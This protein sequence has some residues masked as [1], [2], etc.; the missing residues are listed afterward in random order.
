MKKFLQQSYHWLVLLIAWFAVSVSAMAQDVT[1]QL[2]Q[3]SDKSSEQSYTD[4]GVT[5]HY[6][7]DGMGQSEANIYLGNWPL[8]VTSTNGKNISKIV[9]SN[10]RSL[11]GV[12]AIDGK[13]SMTSSSTSSCTWEAGSGKY[14]LV[15]FKSTTDCYAGQIE[16]WFADDEQGG[17]T[18][19][20]TG[21]EATDPNKLSAGFNF[22]GVIPY[23]TGGSPSTLTSGKNLA[24]GD[25]FEA[26]GVTM[27]MTAT[28]LAWSNSAER[29]RLGQNTAFTIA[30]PENYEITKIVFKTD[31]QNIQLAWVQG[32][33]NGDYKTV[34]WTGNASSL[35]FRAS[36]D[37]YIQT[38]DVTCNR[39]AAKDYTVTFSGDVPEGC[40]ATLGTQTFTAEGTYSSYDKLG[41]DDLQVSTTEDYYYDVT[42]DEA[43]ATYTVTFTEYRHYTV[44]VT[45]CDEEGA[46]VRYG[47]DAYYAGD[48]INSKEPLT[49]DDLFV[50]PVNGYKD[51]TVSVGDVTVYVTYTTADSNNYTVVISGM[52]EAASVTIGDETY[53]ANGTYEFSSNKTYTG[54][55]V[56]IDCPETHYTNDRWDCYDEET[57]T[58]TITFSQYYAYSVAVDGESAYSGSDAGVKTNGSTY[59]ADDTIY[60]RGE[61][62]AADAQALYVDGYTGTVDFA[63]TTFT[64][65]Y[66]KNDYITFDAAS[67]AGYG[68]YNVTKEGVTLTGWDGGDYFIAY[69]QNN[70][71]F[72]INSPEVPVAKVV[73]DYYWGLPADGYDAIDGCSKG[74]M[75]EAYTEWT[76]SANYLELWNSNAYGAQPRSI[77]VYL[78]KATPYTISI[79]GMPESKEAGIIVNG[80]YYNGVYDQ[81]GQYTYNSYNELTAQSIQTFTPESHKVSTTFDATSKTFEIVYTALPK[82]EVVAAQD[83]AYTGTE[84]VIKVDCGNG[85][86]KWA[87]I[88]GAFY[89]DGELTAD[90]IELLPMDGFTGTF[91]FDLTSETITVKYEQAAAKTYT[92]VFAGTEIPESASVTVD[93]NTVNYTGTT[94]SFESPYTYTAEQ[95]QAAEVDGYTATVE[96]SE[97]TFTVTYTKVYAV[98]F[99]FTTTEGRNTIMIG[100]WGN[101]NTYD[102]SECKESQKYNKDGISL[103]AQ[104]DTGSFKSQKSSNRFYLNGDD[105]L[106]VE[107]NEEWLI[108]GVELISAS[109]SFPNLMYA[110]SAL[111]DYGTQSDGLYHGT[112]PKE[113]SSTQSVKSIAFPNNYATYLGKIIVTLEPDPT[114]VPKEYVDCSGF[115]PAPTASAESLE[116]IT[117]TFGD[118]T[119]VLPSTIETVTIN[120]QEK[121]AT[122]TA[123]GSVLTI[124]LAEA[125]TADGQYTLTL[126]KETFTTQS[127]KYNSAIELIF[128][129][130]NPYFEV[131]DAM[132]DPNPAENVVLTGTESFNRFVVKTNL[133]L[134]A[135][136]TNGEK[137][138]RLNS[139]PAFNATLEVLYGEQSVAFNVPAQVAHGTYTY[140]IPA[141]VI[142][143]AN[144]KKNASFEVTYTISGPTAPEYTGVIPTT[145]NNLEETVKGNYQI[146]FSKDL[147]DEFSFEK[148]TIELPDGV[149]HLTYDQWANAVPFTHQENSCVVTFSVGEYLEMLYPAA[150]EH[151][152]T[153][154]FAFP[155]GAFTSTDGAK[156][157]EFSISYNYVAPVYYTYNVVFN[158]LEDN[159]N[160][161]VFYGEQKVGH[162]GDVKVKKTQLADGDVTAD[163][164]TG[165]T[166]TIT[167]TQPA[168]GECG[169]ILVQ[170]AAIPQIAFTASPAEGTV[171]L[172]DHE[173]GIGSVDI[174]FEGVNID[175]FYW[176]GEQ[177][178]AGFELK[179]ADGNPLNTQIQS[180][181]PAGNT[182]KINFTNAIAAPG[183]YTFTIPTG[184]FFNTDK[185]ISAGGDITWT[186]TAPTT[187]RLSDYALIGV[188]KNP[189]SERDETVKNLT[190]V[191]INAPEGMTFAVT[192]TLQLDKGVFNYDTYEYDYTP[193]DVTSEV[194]T[195]GNVLTLTFAEPI[196]EKGNYQ[197]RL[198]AGSLSAGELTSKEY[199]FRASVDP[200]F[201]IQLSGLSYTME[202]KLEG[203]AITFTQTDGV[204]YTCGETI[205]VNGSDVAVNTEVTPNGVQVTFR[206]AYTNYT[207]YNIL[208]P[209]GF[210]TA[211]NGEKNNERSQYV[212]LVYS[213]TKFLVSGSTPA[214]GAELDGALEKITLT[215]GEAGN[216]YVLQPFDVTVYGPNGTSTVSASVTNEDWYSN[217]GQVVLTLSEPISAPGD[218]SINIPEGVILNDWQA[219]NAS[220]HNEQYGFKFVVPEPP[221]NEFTGNVHI[222]PYNENTLVEAEE[223]GTYIVD[224]ISMFTLEFETAQAT[225][226]VA[227]T[228]VTITDAEDNTYDV[229]MAWVEGDKVWI[230]AAP[231]IT[232]PGTYTVHFG[233]GLFADADG[234]YN[235]ETEV[236]FVIPDIE[237]FAGADLSLTEGQ[238]VNIL[239]ELVITAPEGVTFDHTAA[240]P[241]NYFYVVGPG[242]RDG[243]DGKRYNDATI[244]EDGTTVTLDLGDY[245]VNGE[246]TITV[247]KG[248]IRT[249]TAN[250]GNDEIVLHV[251]V[252]HVVLPGDANDDGIVETYDVQVA[253]NAVL[254]RG[255]GY[256]IN[257]DALLKAVDLNEDGEITIGEITKLIQQ[258]QSQEG[259]ED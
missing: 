135:E 45:G 149:T 224:K 74:S 17:G 247:P 242:L 87:A 234:L 173:S 198:A 100:E 146:A 244:S 174:E 59:H 120:G 161:Y 131:T 219:E 197:F 177:I 134:S 68:N 92:V 179:D 117:L 213:A 141:G 2:K 64:V 18:D 75:N 118:E 31:A 56:E 78:A 243:D 259:A 99:D 143:A 3:W 180:I 126:P 6:F 101:I 239:S 160:L 111:I 167:I 254:Q 220:K 8:D 32:I 53:S 215:M 124:T 63:G 170:Y 65:S 199:T 142:V 25:V 206:E 162:L 61:L 5:V 133:T 229:N 187:F 145:D 140:K 93:G 185:Q 255:L 15:T 246:Y 9:L 86:F 10:G 182:I 186:L 153:F 184:V 107:A 80:D 115:T 12:Y 214:N 102:G 253:V 176:S 188:R 76:G 39:L 233:A 49:E 27:T 119:L 249:K 190:G 98:T 252:N 28:S 79:E 171:S 26:N 230:Y 168:D 106:V 104:N 123:E 137:Q 228:D 181:W 57:G 89:Y 201:D 175:Y 151:D 113:G 241:D 248:Y 108:K 130:V 69:D 156:S 46:G 13:G 109:S 81:N 189:D 164:V 55:N 152:G 257:N 144:G 204:N 245:K 258:L 236:V 195:E 191:T 202:E 196:A 84:S 203:F 209:A 207:G 11:N 226:T 14:T 194:N 155:Y 231:T 147:T 238:E 157:E 163:D 1:I 251:N 154:T 72:V 77:K 139:N 4:S 70:S 200:N 22:N 90:A 30:A 132:L 16:I 178:P 223:D 37:T 43:E 48:K 82:Y 127:G 114:Y 97:G 36:Y 105:N 62:T 50:I 211:S 52:P 205:K 67:V 217:S 94:H 222:D 232:K 41:K 35:D 47:Y 34:T 128:N 40:S 129:V 192:P 159:D 85:E 110:S 166:K 183:E 54:Y 216:Y 250:E 193:V 208:V 103:Y 116:T 125:I 235:A 165:Y 256:G 38:I 95:A 148:A 60:S 240:Y 225:G 150:F 58:F 19:T 136:A 112:W 7:Q 66:T 172:D 33:D 237:T 21:S 20:G 51:G 96:Y 73:I 23:T 227:K 42:Y 71:H 158:G 121:A 122:V 169:V 210:I 83:N 212:N 138:I 218:Y 29:L 88:G 24:V 91:D 221:M 44:S